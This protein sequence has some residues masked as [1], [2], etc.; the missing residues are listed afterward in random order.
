MISL[1][2]SGV[3]ALFL[4]QRHMGFML[5]LLAPVLVPWFGYSVY[6]ATT[7]PA[8]RIDQ[9]ARVAVWLLAVI[10]VVATHVFW[11]VTTRNQANQIVAAIQ[12]YMRQHG[13]CPENL[14]VIGITQEQLRKKTGLSGYHCERGEP[15]FI[16]AV[17][18][19]VFET[20]DYDFK[21]KEW[22]YWPD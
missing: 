14:M 12:S 1:M 6:V 22:R 2:V 15:Q 13:R 5:I 21:R 20:Y 9:L 16:Y 10:S 4:S 3:V 19:A 11:H 7:Q 17:T 18:F 8:R